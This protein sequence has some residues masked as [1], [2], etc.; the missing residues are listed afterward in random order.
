MRKHA[1]DAHPDKIA[2]FAIVE[3]PLGELGLVGALDLAAV[4]MGAVPAMSEPA[5]TFPEPAGVARRVAKGEPHDLGLVIGQGAFR[6]LPDPV[7]D[8]RRLIE[9]SN[10]AQIGTPDWNAP[11]TVD[12]LQ[13]GN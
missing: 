8:R 10:G 6:D 4:D 3:H 9:V 5:K 13:V 2:V 1:L 7:T 11:L 12:S